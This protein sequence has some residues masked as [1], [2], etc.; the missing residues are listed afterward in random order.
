M[1]SPLSPLFAVGCIVGGLVLLVAPTVIPS[2]FAPTSHVRLVGLFSLLIGALEARSLIRFQRRLRIALRNDR[3]QRL[4]SRQTREVSIFSTGSSASEDLARRLTTVFQ[5]IGDTHVTKFNVRTER[6]DIATATI[7]MDLVVIDVT[8]EGCAGNL[9]KLF[10]PTTRLA[11]VVL[12]SRNYLPENMSTPYEKTFPSY[13]IGEM[14]N[15]EI[16][17]HL[18]KQAETL[19]ASGTSALKGM[20]IKDDRVEIAP[21]ASSLSSDGVFISYRGKYQPK[22]AELQAR[23][24]QGQFGSDRVRARYVETGALVY[25]NELLTE[26]RRWYLLELLAEHIFACDEFWIYGA[27][28]HFKSWWTIGELALFALNPRSTKRL[29]I[30]D[31]GTDSVTEVRDDLQPHLSPLEKV[32]LESW[33]QS[34]NLSFAAQDRANINI[35][36]AG[37]VVANQSSKFAVRWAVIL[38]LYLFWRLTRWYEVHKDLDLLHGQPFRNFVQLSLS[39]YVWGTVRGRPLKPEFWQRLELLVFD[40]PDVTTQD[41]T[42]QNRT[43]VPSGGWPSFDQ[44]FEFQGFSRIPVTAEEISQGSVTANNNRWRL[45]RE[46]PRYSMSTRPGGGDL[47]GCP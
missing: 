33:L 10:S 38:P 30:Y 12:V 21:N 6:V 34:S 29:V 32:H 23:L 46:K 16:V 35:V 4:T 11:N 20:T 43:M 45:E 5:G 13:A 39:P 2:A 36:R 44:L 9:E 22:V 15:D 14:S 47:V 3:F 41:R 37:Q 25:E 42:E 18:A 27:A 40:H 26:Q 17:Q 1:F 24:K 31:P 8:R 19:V 7:S 28:D